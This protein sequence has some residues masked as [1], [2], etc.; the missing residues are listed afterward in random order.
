MTD[1]LSPLGMSAGDF[2]LA[3]AP[4][5]KAYY[6]FERVHSETI[7]ANLTDN[8]TDVTGYY[9]THFPHPHPPYVREATAHFM[10]DGKHYLITSGTT[11]Y[12]PNPSEVSVADSWHGPFKI[13]GDPCP[14][15]SS[16]TTYHTQI[17]SV[18]K[19]PDKRGL[20]IAI[21]DRWCPDLMD[22]PY[23]FYEELFDARFSGKIPK[24]KLEEYSEKLAL[25]HG[26]GKEVLKKIND[27]ERDTSVSEYVW[28]P[29][30]FEASSDKNP[31]GM[32]YLDWHDEWRLEDYN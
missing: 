19:V 11:G 4:D 8:Y 20:Y 5:G 6:Y 21:G 32:V 14:N 28:L 17:S 3:V 31:D 24:D 13:L 9:S 27:F 22:L 10:R 26:L 18:F 23:S 2:D 16:R 12:L 29:L 15:D 1:H 25:K 30:R 7:C